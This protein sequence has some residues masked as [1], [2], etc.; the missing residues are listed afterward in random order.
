MPRPPHP[1]R[2]VKTLRSITPL[3]RLVASWRRKG[4][5]VALVPTMGNLHAGHL[6]L[7]AQARRHADRIVVSVFV[8]PTQFG[9][10]EDY[11]S[12]PRTL[13]ADRRALRAAGVDALFAP[14]I[15][16]MYPRGPAAATTVAVPGLSRELCGRFRP[17]HFAGVTSVVCRLFNIVAPDIAVFG[18]KDYQQLVIIRQM[19]ADLHLPVRILGAATVREPDGLALSSRNQ[20]LTP[21]ERQVAAELYRTLRESAAQL[22]A[23]RRNF[24]AIERQARR[25]LEA[26]GF[27][28]DYV[29]I[30]EDKTLALPNATTRRFRVLA[31]ARLGRARLIDNIAV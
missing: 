12:Y 16:A 26:A 20:Y 1:H 13:A 22:H 24:R 3:R 18:E 23:G 28:P 19:A 31:A 21:R 30:R 5:S 17:T 29:E 4:K 15:A 10:A 2:C 8:N 9:P 14:D 6:S 11:H 27:R 25:R 7:V